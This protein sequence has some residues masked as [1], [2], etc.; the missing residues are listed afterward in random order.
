M[1]RGARRSGARRPLVPARRFGEGQ[2]ALGYSEPLNRA[3]RVKRDDDGLHVRERIIS[4]YSK[5][6]F[7][8]IWPDDLRN[9]MRWWGLY[10]QRRQ[11]VPGGRTAAAEPWELE[12]EHFMLRVRIPG[13]QLTSGQLR[14]IAWVSER[15][16]R[17]VADVTDRQNVQL[18]WIRIED[19]PRIW[20]AIEAVGL[21][22]CEACGDTPRN[23]L[24][25]PLAGVDADEVIDA[26]PMLLE[27]HRRWVGDEALSNLPRKF[28]TT[29]SGCPQQ[30]GQHE[31][32]DV[33]F[34][35]TRRGGSADGE[36]GFDLWAGGGLGPNPK[37]AKRLGVF[38]EPEQVPEVWYGIARLF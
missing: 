2:W 1:E 37:F 35:G 7:S 29:M 17:D 32:N 4:T 18:H 15:F 6:G 23:F 14:A 27:T 28:K 36:P 31:V 3:E 20:E 26:T 21:S 19:I 25:C 11:G 10:T 9:R 8:S 33:G 34:V 30:C 24:G 12:D 16:G 13:G 38:V 5:Q 22:T